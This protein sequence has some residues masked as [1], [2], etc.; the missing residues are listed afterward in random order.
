MLRMFKCHCNCQSLQESDSQ[1]LVG[2]PRRACAPE[3]RRVYVWGVLQA[4]CKT[5][6]FNSLPCLHNMGIVQRIPSSKSCLQKLSR[7]HP[8]LTILYPIKGGRKS[9]GN[10]SNK[11]S[12]KAP[13]EF[14]LATS[15]QLPLQDHHRVHHLRRLAVRGAGEAEVVQVLHQGG[16]MLQGHP[17]PAIRVVLLIHASMKRK[18]CGLSSMNI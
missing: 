5:H 10:G 1:G 18:S 15:Y 13:K 7:W 3:N 9:R 17:A 12:P 2:T 6:K 8:L 16:R 11:C 4:Q 14:D